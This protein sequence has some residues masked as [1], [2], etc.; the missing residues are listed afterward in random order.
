MFL[1]LQ[2]PSFHNGSV[3]AEDSSGCVNTFLQRFCGRGDH[4]CCCHVIHS[5]FS[6]CRSIACQKH[7]TR[8]RTHPYFLFAMENELMHSSILPQHMKALVFVHGGCTEVN[9]HQREKEQPSEIFPAETDY[10]IYALAHVLDIR[11]KNFR[12]VLDE[13]FLKFW[14]YRKSIRPPPLLRSSLHWFYFFL[15]DRMRYVAL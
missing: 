12:S 4:S 10:S 13:C 15:R 7:D 14:Y 8:S 11:K 5:Q 3:I 2:Y 6:R 1:A 9:E